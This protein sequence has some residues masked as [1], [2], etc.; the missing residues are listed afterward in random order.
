VFYRAAPP[1]YSLAATTRCLRGHGFRVSPGSRELGFPAIAISRKGV[2]YR[3]TVTF[4]SGE[5]AA[6]RVVEANPDSIPP[7]R[8][9]N[10]V[11]DWEGGPFPSF[12]TACLRTR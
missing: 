12:L 2:G 5:A 9:R 7:P 11:L 6:R 8:E 3:G 1:N 10:V 4:A